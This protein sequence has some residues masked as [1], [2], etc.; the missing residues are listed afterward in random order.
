MDKLLSTSGVRIGAQSVG[1][2]LY[3]IGRILAYLTGMKEPKFVT[4]F[5][6]A[7]KSIWP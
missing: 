3:D 6:Q 1:H 7:T 2:N 4:G 5:A